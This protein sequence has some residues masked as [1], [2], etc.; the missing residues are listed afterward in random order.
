MLEQIRSLIAA[1][2]D[3][4]DAA[5][6]AVQAILDTV[7]AEGRSD[8]TEAEIAA[9]LRAG[10]IEGAEPVLVEKSR[11]LFGSGCLLGIGQVGERYPLLSR[12][13]PLEHSL[14]R[15]PRDGRRARGVVGSDGGSD[16]EENQDECEPISEGE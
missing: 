16:T 6:K 15:R 4:R 9:E 3:E 2:L 14:H 8:L 7:E 1:A 5:D 12:L 11:G 13:H 10:E